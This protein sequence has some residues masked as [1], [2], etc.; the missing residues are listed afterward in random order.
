[1]V[2][3]RSRTRRNTPHRINV[4]AAADDRVVGRLVNI[5]TGG[6]MFLTTDRVLKGDAFELRIP[7]PTMT[8]NRTS[9]E[10]SGVVVWLGADTSPPYTRV[11]LRFA[12]LGAEE[13]FII[14]TVLQRLH[15]VG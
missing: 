10:V 13:G 8:S 6:L 4:L 12:N 3:K 7:L 14:E 9:I 5:T 15:L 2:D 1:M 11:G